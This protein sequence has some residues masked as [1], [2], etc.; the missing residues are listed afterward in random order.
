M[1]D[2]DCSVWALRNTNGHRLRAGFPVRCRYRQGELPVGEPL[3]ARGGSEPSRLVASF[4]APLR[5][6]IGTRYSEY[7]V[8][9]MVNGVKQV[10]FIQFVVGADGVWRIETM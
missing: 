9:R 5:A 8:V 2:N 10:H 3:A 6:S 1:N 4:S 7:A